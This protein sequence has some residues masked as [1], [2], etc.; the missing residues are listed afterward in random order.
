MNVN[1]IHCM[2]HFQVW[3]KNRRAKWRKR[4]RNVANEQI[5]QATA[6]ATNGFGAQFN[7]LINSAFEDPSSLYTGYASGYTNGWG[8]KV[9]P[10]AKSAFT[11]PGLNTVG[12]S[13]AMFGT[14]SPNS[15]SSSPYTPIHAA[16]AAAAYHRSNA[17]SALTP[18]LSSGSSGSVTSA[19]RIKSSKSPNSS[20]TSSPTTA[21]ALVTSS[22]MS[23]FAAPLSS[24]PQIGSYGS[25]ASLA[26]NLSPS[27]QCHYDSSTAPLTPN[28]VSDTN[29]NVQ[30]TSCTLPLF[31]TLCSYYFIYL[32]S[33]ISFSSQLI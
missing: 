22:I 5:R 24:P 29:S 31:I 1:L 18:S 4:E 14:G 8:S 15:T 2:I 32:Q 12:A 10:G 21:S 3:F 13:A 6:A 9:S 11:W 16:A 17:D 20:A 27:P 26:S 7:G 30:S 23:P 19:V 25:S 28:T 33:S